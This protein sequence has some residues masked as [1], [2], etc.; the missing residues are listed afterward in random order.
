VSRAREREDPLGNEPLEFLGDAVLGLVVSE[1][2]M[3]RHPERPE[4]WLSRARAGAVNKHALARRARQLELERFIRL[5]RGELRSGGAAKPGIL[6]N[7]FEAVLGALYLD[8]G[9]DAVRALVER[10]LGDALEQP[11][12]ALADSKTRLQEWLQA[13]GEPPPRYETTQASGPPH[14]PQFHVEV[15]VGERVRGQGT[16]GSKRAAEQLAA[17]AALARLEDDD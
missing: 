2:L 10:E 9:L 1:L 11:E 12:G 5:G 3:E 15:R 14:A 4:G 16:A 13:R 7:A 17:S 8:A 6:A